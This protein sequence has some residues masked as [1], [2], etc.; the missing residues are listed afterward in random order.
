M[1]SAS[2]AN[3]LRAMPVKPDRPSGNDGFVSFTQV[4]VT[5]AKKDRF[6]VS[7]LSQK[8]II[9]GNVHSRQSLT[10]PLPVAGNAAAAYDSALDLMSETT[11][12]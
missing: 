3:V 7:E 11:S 2:P 10:S 9:I 4:C 5:L 1:R 6:T 8:S 12:E